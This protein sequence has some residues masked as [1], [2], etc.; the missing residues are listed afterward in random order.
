MCVCLYAAAVREKEHM[1]ENIC[2]LSYGDDVRSFFY[3]VVFFSL[4]D[5]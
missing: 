1:C 5:I 2:G 3:F 4:Q